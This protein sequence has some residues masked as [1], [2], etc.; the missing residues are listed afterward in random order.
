M[1]SLN[2]ISRYCLILGISLGLS[3][4]FQIYWL[5][6]DGP[7]IREGGSVS[8]FL[9]KVTA[10]FL[11]YVGLYRLL[12]V[13]VFAYN[14]ALKVP[15]LYYFATVITVLPYI[16][17][18]SY[19]QA[20]N[21]AFF[22]P[23]L[24]VNYTEKTGLETYRFMINVIVCVV[25]AQ[26]FIDL[27]L[28]LAG[29][30]V[31]ITLLGG[32]G[33]ANTFGL[34]LI[35]SALACRFIYFRE[36]ASRLLLLIVPATGS[37]ACS[38]IAF[39]FLLHSFLTKVKLKSIPVAFFSLAGI[40]FLIF[41]F[42]DLIYQENNPVWHAHMK[43][44]GLINYALNEQS[45]STAS[46]SIREEYSKHGLLLLAENPI[47]V[48]F[49]HPDFLPF[50]SGDGFYI[51]LLVTVGFPITFFFIVCNLIAI[52]RGLREGQ[53]LS[54]FS[55]Y[56]VLIFLILFLSNR[57]LDYWP[58]SLIYLLAFSFLIRKKSYQGIVEKEDHRV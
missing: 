23:L 34:Y 11:I 27:A 41:N 9:M 15:I 53:P 52:Y 50:Y 25:T 44:L 36:N 24:F 47:A 39:I 13:S 45:V 33:N 58:S 31:T 38:V 49:G 17:N 2:N 6:M 46:I 3:I 20:L 43:F 16:Y 51:A 57:I 29:L 19:N 12:S 7:H 8:R 28:K 5:G 10:F 1:V 14:L 30:Q 56:V 21:L 4:L 55:A 48:I 35:V 42:W 22:I 54:I 32:M 18:N 40:G 26:V 37:L